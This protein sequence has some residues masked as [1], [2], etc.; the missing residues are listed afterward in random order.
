MPIMAYF[1]SCLREFAGYWTAPV[2][3]PPD[4]DSMEH[5]TGSF[6]A[7]EWRTSSGNRLTWV[8]AWYSVPAYT[9]PHIR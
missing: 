6:P 4:E 8:E 2:I 9:P 5:V 7:P 3:E 1:G